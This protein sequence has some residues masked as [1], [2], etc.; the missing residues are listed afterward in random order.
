[1][2]CLVAIVSGKRA[3]LAADS[4][5][6]AGWVRHSMSDTK[7]FRKDRL[8]LGVSG[9]IRAANIIAEHWTPPRW[10]PGDDPRG[11]MIR[12]AIP[13][14]REILDEHGHLRDVNGV[15][16]VGEKDGE[17][18]LLAVLAGSIF[19]IGSDLSVLTTAESYA[20]R[21]SGQEYALGVLHH[22][23]PIAADRGRQTAAALAALRAAARFDLGCSPPYYAVY[24]D[25][26]GGAGPERIGDDG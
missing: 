3:I 4:Q 8:L 9:R 20:A 14:L 12:E 15:W 16:T 19:L 17:S 26:D 7:V 18:V 11:W 22:L 23:S 13:S 10:H 2:T 25:G 21:G 5:A 6:T 1:M 24:D